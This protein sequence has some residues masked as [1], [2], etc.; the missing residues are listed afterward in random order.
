MPSVEYLDSEE[1]S[2]TIVTW[3]GDFPHRA[4]KMILQKDYL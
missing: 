2:N 4:C 1:L 3:V